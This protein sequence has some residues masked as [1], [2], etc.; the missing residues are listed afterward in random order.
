MKMPT[1]EQQNEFLRKYIA[2]LFE[3]NLA[4][5]LR[6]Y[7]MNKTMSQKIPFNDERFPEI[8]EVLDFNNERMAQIRKDVLADIREKGE[9]YSDTVYDRTFDTADKEEVRQ[10][11][12]YSSCPD[13][14]ALH[15]THTRPLPFEKI[16]QREFYRLSN[17]AYLKATFKGYGSNLGAS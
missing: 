5:V 6:N 13:L 10:V 3:F 11:S 9:S 17:P 2:P 4:K 14:A 8:K 12:R 15:M 7:R 1:Y 16:L